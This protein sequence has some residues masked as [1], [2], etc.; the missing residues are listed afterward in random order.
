ATSRS[1]GAWRFRADREGFQGSTGEGLERFVRDR[2]R[3]Y[4]SRRRGTPGKADHDENW[5]E[6]E[7]S[8]RDQAGRSVF[9]R[10]AEGDR[11]GERTKNGGGQDLERGDGQGGGGQAR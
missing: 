2:A 5:R 1:R 3:R 4:P 10:T 6:D 8:G 7:I 11:P 9:P